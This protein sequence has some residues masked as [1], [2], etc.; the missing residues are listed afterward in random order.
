MEKSRS[1]FLVS[2]V[3]SIKVI[4][5][6]LVLT[7]AILIAACLAIQVTGAQASAEGLNMTRDSIHRAV[8]QCYALEGFYPRDLQYLCDHY[9][10]Q[11][12]ETRYIVHYQYIASNLLP[13]ITVLIAAE[14]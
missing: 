1:L 12:D 7:I 8:V 11:L 10:L 3:K 2:P 4:V 6:P 9:G 14:S 5:I 13:D